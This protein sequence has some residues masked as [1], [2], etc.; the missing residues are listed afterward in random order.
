MDMI[1]SLRLLKRDIGSFFLRLGARTF[2][3]CLRRLEL[4]IFEK[5]TLRYL[6]SNGTT[7]QLAIS[8]LEEL[9][10]PCNVTGRDLAHGRALISFGDT[11]FN[12]KPIVL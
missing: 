8:H 2:Q 4:P 7:Q 3:L 12:V 5:R 11:P 1:T 9:H 6:I 10:E